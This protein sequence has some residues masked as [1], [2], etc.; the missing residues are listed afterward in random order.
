MVK[1]QNEASGLV[2]YNFKT[3]LEGGYGAEWGT[4]WR[5]GHHLHRVP[6][7]SIMFLIQ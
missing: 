3:R 5:E 4:D 6:G 2:L 7:I 1:E